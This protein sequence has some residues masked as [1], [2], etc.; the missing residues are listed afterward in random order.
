MLV[1]HFHIHIYIRASRGRII[2]NSNI[3]WFYRRRRR[4]RSIV[5]LY[6]YS[7]GH[8]PRAYS[9][10]RRRPRKP[11][12]A[13]K[14]LTPRTK[15]SRWNLWS[16]FPLHSRSPFFLSPACVYIPVLR[17]TLPPLRIPRGY[18][19]RCYLL[20]S[21]A[22]PLMNLTAL[23]CYTKRIVFSRSCPLFIHIYFFFSPFYSV[24]L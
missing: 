16:F 10:C 7:R 21:R 9:R 12:T 22:S 8:I 3:C 15:F 1:L 2:F 5:V 20:L 23:C 14:T 24:F 17:C 18:N 6:V 4:R 19:I 13:E 11:S